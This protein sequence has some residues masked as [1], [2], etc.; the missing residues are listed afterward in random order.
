M[1]Y[2][3]ERFAAMKKHDR[4]VTTDQFHVDILCAYCVRH[5]D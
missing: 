5:A 2:W 4:E 3:D 1:P